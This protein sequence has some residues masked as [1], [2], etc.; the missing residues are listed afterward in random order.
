M[1]R[2]VLVLTLLVA[3]CSFSS[4]GFDHGALARAARVD[5]HSV[6]DTD[7]AGVVARR[8]PP[9]LPLRLAVWFRPPSSWRWSEQRFRWQEQ[10][11]SAVLGAMGRLQ[12]AGVVSDVFVLADSVFPADSVRAAR[13]AA[14]LQNADAVLIV[15][16][17]SE[18]QRH[19][20]AAAL[21]YATVVGLWVA[22]GSHAEGICLATGSVWDVRSGTLF[23]AAEAQATWSQTAP[24]MHVDE[25]EV[26]SG[27]KRSAL[28][29]LARD[30]EIRLA[31]LGAAATAS[32]AVR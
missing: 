9:K 16:G 22:P 8:S 25:E 20:N 32:A 23:A 11:Q 15:T 30:L 12:D 29:T 1:R 2:L 28:A 24:V 7:I 18:V 5:R 21:L 19:S 13:F 4:R 31:K 3:G 27:A 14:A 26:V 6:S 17:V 10:D